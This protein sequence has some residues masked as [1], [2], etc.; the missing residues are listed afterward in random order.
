LRSEAERYPE[1][2][3]VLAKREVNM[4]AYLVLDVSVINPQEFRKY[5]EQVRPTIEDHGG[6]VL[7]SDKPEVLEGTWNKE[8]IV[9]VQFP[10]MEKAKAWYNSREYAPL[11][12][13]R[14][15]SSTSSFLVLAPGVQV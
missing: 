9:I 14:L 6:K 8:R 2:S 13:L 15:R 3:A 4:A 1:P 7:S 12:S 11:K 5:R 10:S